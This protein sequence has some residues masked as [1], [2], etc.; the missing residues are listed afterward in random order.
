M[1]IDFTGH[2]TVIGK[3]G[4]GKTY[5]TRKSLEKVKGGVLFFNTMLGDMPG[6]VQA[7]KENTWEQIG[8][9]LAKGGK[10]NYMPGLDRELRNKELSHLVK[11]LYE[12]GKNVIFAVDEVHLYDR[13]ATNSLVEIATTGRHFGIK[14]VFISQRPANVDNTLMTQS[15]QFVIFK[16]NMEQGYFDRYKMPGEEIMERIKAG[17]QY[18][19]VT[20]DWESLK[21]AYKA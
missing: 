16:L 2:C 17:G 14:G 9:I 6:F 13:T 20:Y 8:A 21:G 19:Y 1:L 3:T 4:S 7:G 11:K 5:A 12:S 15:E 10:V 18:A